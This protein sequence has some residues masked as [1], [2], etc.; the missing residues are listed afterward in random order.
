MRLPQYSRVSKHSFVNIVWTRQHFN[1]NI[2]T[3]W[4]I[5]KKK[6]RLHRII[7]IN[8]SMNIIY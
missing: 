6:F 5:F 4:F 1:E 3:I 8:I 2:A 7:I